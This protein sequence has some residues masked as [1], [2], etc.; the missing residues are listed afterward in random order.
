MSPPSA[1]PAPPP[2][3]YAPYAPPPD[4]PAFQPY[5]YRPPRRRTPNIGAREH[6][7]FF[8]R[9]NAGV[10]A[11]SAYYRERITSGGPVSH[12]K[13]R[14]VAGSFQVAIGGS[15]FDNLILHGNMAVTV[16]SA[17]KEVDGIKDTSDD[18]LSTTMWLFG[19]GATYYFMPTNIYLTLVLGA[20]ALTERRREKVLV[21]GTIEHGPTTYVD[22]GA[23]FGSSLTLGKEW[24]VGG[25]GEWGI[26]AALTGAFYATPLQISGVSSTFLAQSVSLCFSSTLN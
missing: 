9:F 10:G 14:G 23:G 4:Y 26:G 17:N 12:I 20:S 19:G 2:P 1:P 21:N 13:T 6:D 15:V 7:G 22:S 18:E 16:V 3:Y 25:R 11:G 5:P 24:W 8:L